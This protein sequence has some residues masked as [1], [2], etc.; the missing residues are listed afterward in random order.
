MDISIYAQTLYSSSFLRKTGGN[1]KG[2]SGS[3]FG[4]KSGKAAAKTAEKSGVDSS[5]SEEIREHIKNLSKKKTEGPK[6][7]VG[8]S[9]DKVK[10]YLD[11]ATTSTSKKTEKVKKP[12]RY[13]YK[14]V[15]SKIL[16]AKTSVS[17]GQAVLAA[18]R[19]VIEVR[20]QIS[21]G[22]GDAE[23]LQLALTHAKRMEMV[24]RKKKHNLEL[25]EMVVN[26]QRRDENM[27]KMEEA[28][29]DIQSALVSAEEEKVTKE[30]DAIFEERQEMLEEAAEEAEE[31]SAEASEEMLD[32]LNK[33]ISEFGEEELKELEEEMEMLENMEIIDPHMS[34]EE[35]EEL[36]RKHRAAESRAIVKADMDYLKGMIKHQMEKGN[37]VSGS[38][39]AGNTFSMPAV[40][41]TSSVEV[42]MP[43]LA[44]TDGMTLDI[45][46]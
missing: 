33:M 19:K 3:V 6:T 38:S 22:D 20:R 16:R 25:E 32:K 24:A 26:T 44:E 14:E 18:K 40:T 31:R 42:A 13:S 9:Q 45:Q 10:G 4:K 12:V 5:R 28:S 36:K 39:S 15:S 46:I 41:Y 34:E 8:V 17:A 43:A 27:D 30:E 23:E 37:S 2:S 1:A 11:L 29:D 35:L 21:S 7:F